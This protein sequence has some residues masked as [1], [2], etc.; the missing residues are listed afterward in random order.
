MGGE[1]GIWLVLQ[2]FWRREMD[3]SQFL[4]ERGVN[5]FIPMTC[6]EHHVNGQERPKRL[7]VPVVHNYIFFES[8]MDG[9]QLKSLLGECRVPVCLL[10]HKGT[11][12]PCAI[13]DREMVEFRLLCDPKYSGTVF[14]LEGQEDVE[15]G[16]EVVITHGQFAGIRGRL[17]R[18]QQKYWFV[19]TV[20]GIS[21]MMR[22]TR[23]FCK[24][25]N[26]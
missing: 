21:V 15:V 25:I 16:K 1:K 4:T 8:T 7:L 9:S 3:V 12:V 20:A 11:D 13:S 5:H 6:R 22:I 17:L 18:K 23:W 19:K 14:I 2:T 24:P 10:K 26:K